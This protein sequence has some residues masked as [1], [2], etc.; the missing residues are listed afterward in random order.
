MDLDRGLKRMARW[1]GIG[2]VAAIVFGI[3]ALV[4]PGITLVSLT[5]LFGAFAFV[6]GVF[7]IAAGLNLLAHRSTN[8]VAPV[9]GGI[10]GVLIG[11]ITYLHPA[12]T[13]AALTYL[14]AAWAFVIGIVAI[15]GAIE[16]WNEVRGAVWLAISGVLSVAFGVMVAVWPG[17]GLL[18]IIWLIG[19][20]AVL[21]GVAQL[22]GSYQIHQFRVESEKT[23]GAPQPQAS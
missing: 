13:V 3:V 21:A 10:A 2:G 6:Y 4:W 15:M 20:Y 12:I 22:V 7:G 9:I 18:S 19:L 14:I 23:F 1:L 5:L 16:V 8:W 11:G 17:A